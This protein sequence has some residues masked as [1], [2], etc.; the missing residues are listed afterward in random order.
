MKNNKTKIIEIIKENLLELVD[1]SNSYFPDIIQFELKYNK[2]M[3]HFVSYIDIEDNVSLIKNYKVIC[4]QMKSYES[5]PYGI[6]TV[7]SNYNTAIKPKAS[8]KSKREFEDSIRIAANH[9]KND[10]DTFFDLISKDDNE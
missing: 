4:N 2:L 10:F 8:K 3:E 5:R 6:K 9:I 7:R 1:I